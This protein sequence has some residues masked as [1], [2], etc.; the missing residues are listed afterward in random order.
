MTSLT[1]RFDVVHASSFH[2]SREI[3]PAGFSLVLVKC[4]SWFGY[5]LVCH[6]GEIADVRLIT[7]VD[8]K[9]KLSLLQHQHFTQLSGIV[10]ALNTSNSEKLLAML[11]VW[12][13]SGTLNQMC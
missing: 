9:P 7:G 13:H 5:S 4:A 8:G 12:G 6:H 3:Y 11:C 1:L 10:L 2:S